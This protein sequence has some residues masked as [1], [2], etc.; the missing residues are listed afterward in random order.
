MKRIKCSALLVVL[1]VFMVAL[2]PTAKAQRVVTLT[3]TGTV[4]SGTNCYNSTACAFS[5]GTSNLA[6]L[7][8]QLVYTFDDTQ[9]TE[10]GTTCSG[11]S[12]LNYSNIQNSGSS[13]PGTAVLTI[14]DSGNH[15]HTFPFGGGTMGQT[16]ITSYVTR[17]GGTCNGYS[18]DVFDVNVS[19]GSAGY[20][21]SSNVG[22]GYAL[23][24][25]WPYSGYLGGVSNADWRVPTTLA[26]LDTA[27]T[28]PF[29]INM[30]LNGYVAEYAHG[31][32]TPDYLTIGGF[33][34]I[35]GGENTVL[36]T[37]FDNQ[38][39]SNAPHLGAV[40]AWK[41]T[42]QPSNTN[43][44]IPFSGS[45]VIREQSSGSIT[46]TCYANTI[47]N[48][49]TDL[50][51]AVS[52][53]LGDGGGGDTWN[54]DNNNVYKWDGV[55]WYDNVNGSQT[56]I[57]Y[58]RAHASP[59]PCSYSGGQQMQYLDGSG[60]WHNYGTYQHGGYNLLEGIIDATQVESWRGGQHAIR[61]Y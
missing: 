18:Y 60:T 40:A 34:D 54:V 22:T 35:P 43:N 27:W 19:Y 16:S 46:D 7:S 49:G 56:E 8:Y 14:Y 47:A 55:G 33:Y 38:G 37:S 26:A 41:Q 12:P 51:T 24:T 39:W 20:T 36:D 42:L 57:A 1:L 45:S 48:L 5:V 11:G 4:S 17:Y 6:G 13:N 9:G 53:V 58:Y 21:G 59:I 44:S 28:I 23:P 52:S 10:T 61:T 30:N 25:T 15:P 32:L 29:S 3:I 31:N 2:A 50:F